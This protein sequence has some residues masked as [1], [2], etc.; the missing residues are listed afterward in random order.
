MN[1]VFCGNQK[2]LEEFKIKE[3]KYWIVDLAINQYYLGKCIVRLKRHLED[4]FDINEEEL[5]EFFVI[6]KNLRNV[7]KKVFGAD[8]FNYVTLGNVVRHVHLHFIPRYSKKVK[9]AGY[10]FEDIGWGKHYRLYQ[11][12]DFEIPREV[13]ILIRNRIKEGL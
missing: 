13:K 7:I 1:C 8:M 2:E 4:F 11:K 6:T 5:K 9:F 10:V 12:D 3:Y